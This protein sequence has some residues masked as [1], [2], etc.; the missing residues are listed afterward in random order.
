MYLFYVFYIDFKTIT[1]DRL[2]RDG[3]SLS[4]I[5]FLPNTST[6]KYI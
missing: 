2:G 3:N 5:A 6:I 4:K 1:A